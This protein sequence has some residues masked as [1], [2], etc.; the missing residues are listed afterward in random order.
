M[1]RYVCKYTPIELF[2]G[3]GVSCKPLEAMASQYPD[4]DRLGHANLC[5]FGKS[6]IQAVGDGDA[7]ELV[8]VNCCDV[9]R[10]V[11]DIARKSGKCRFLFLLDLPH[12]D[13]A[14]SRS[15]FVR[16]ILRLKDAYTRYS[17]KEFSVERFL[18]AFVPEKKASG[19]YIGLVGARADASL[20][21][22]VSQ[23]TGYPVENH[24]CLG[25]RFVPRPEGTG[26]AMWDA[27]AAAL[28]AQIPCVRMDRNVGRSALYHDPQLAG[29]VYHAMKFCDF[30]QMECNEALASCSVPSIRIETDYTTQ[31]EGQL[32]TRLEAFR[33][34]LDKTKEPPMKIR[35]GFVAGIDSGSTSTDVVVMDQNQTIVASVILPT[36]RGARASGE[37]ALGKAL[38]EAGISRGQVVRVV[39]TGYGRDSFGDD[40][41][42]TEISC[43][44][45]GA[46]FL[47]P[48]VRTVIDIGGQDS[49]AIRL[50]EAG[51]VVNFAM[52]DKCAAGTGRFLEMMARALDM[53]IDQMARM[54]D[55]ANEKI[56]IS[57]MCT[58]FAESEVVSLVA[59][60]KDVG[61]IV[62]ALDASVASKIAVLVGRVGLTEPVMLT[63]G[64]A[65]NPGVVHALERKLSVPL[66]ISPM[67][68]LC[69]AIGAALFALGK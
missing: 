10:R 2:A 7:E 30:S 36:G 40:Q 28:L 21:A 34:T 11:A 69:G 60:N 23:K 51:G 46:H 53:D 31:S 54:G 5:G 58:V 19:T 1:I 64:V 20:A 67:A 13:I 35:D 29:V 45:K 16:E 44:A 59:K 14:C 57:S 68:Q 49:K 24:T 50:D 66:A 18:S 48:S 26:D 39:A 56:V 55:T 61:D 9:M 62:Y 63:G 52:N 38:E 17:G 42:I 43:H 15:L 65:K 33:E 8:L 37:E 12:E 25:N 41:R 6:V 47:D 22:F 32:T 4:A 3:F 27:Y